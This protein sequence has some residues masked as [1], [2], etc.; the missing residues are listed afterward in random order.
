LELSGKTKVCAVLG[1]P[2]AHSLS[3]T[4]HNAAFEALG[5]DF[6]YLAFRVQIERLEAAIS[7]AKQLGIHGLN[8]TMPCKEA[9]A[10]YLDTVEPTARAVGAVNTV[11]NDN[12]EFVGHNTDGMGALKALEAHN[13][14]P[15][16]KRVLLLGAGGAGKAIAFH[17]AQEA[18]GLDILNRS[19]EKASRLAR[20]LQERFSS[21]TTGS[22]LSPA[23]IRRKLASADIVINA[24]SVGMHPQADQSLVDPNWLRPDLMVME[25]VYNPL[26]T[27]L[28]KDAKRAGAKVVDGIEM[29]VHQGAAAFQMWTKQP[30]PVEVMRQAVLEKVAQGR[31]SE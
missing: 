8:I 31:E 1:D 13:A 20:A 24:T 23:K 15:Q 6:V 7:G 28:V 3:P 10:T 27:R 2:I 25:V 4:M 5:L 9:V 14:G 26:E 11:V 16:G 30:A 17:V 21:K 29:L 18:S 12:G 22:G 19:G